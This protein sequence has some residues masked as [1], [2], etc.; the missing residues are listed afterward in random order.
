MQVPLNEC[1]IAGTDGVPVRRSEHVFEILRNVRE[2][3]LNEPVID[4]S[5]YR[6]N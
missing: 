6:A 2:L 1:S 4:R 5:I 3:Y